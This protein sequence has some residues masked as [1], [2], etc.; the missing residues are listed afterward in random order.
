MNTLVKIK[1]TKKKPLKIK[2]V[3][4]FFPFKIIIYLHMKDLDLMGGSFLSYDYI[5]GIRWG[6]KFELN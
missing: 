5:S 2:Y 6:P 1:N 3:Y 4:S